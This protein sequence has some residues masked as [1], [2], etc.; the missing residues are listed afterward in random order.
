M[1]RPEH[2]VCE[3]AE[4]TKQQYCCINTDRTLYLLCKTAFTNVLK[5]RFVSRA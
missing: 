4:Q 3:N 5:Q 2:I 1:V